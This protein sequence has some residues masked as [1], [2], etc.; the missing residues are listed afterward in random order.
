MMVSVL[1]TLL[2]DRLIIPYVRVNKGVRAYE[3]KPTCTFAGE[4]TNLA[5][6][7]GLATDLRFGKLR[8]EH[9]SRMV[10]D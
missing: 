6:G 3:N 7:L 8:K 4:V 5:A 1:R 10:R 9:P 2:I